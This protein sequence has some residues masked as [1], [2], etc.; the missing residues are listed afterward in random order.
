[1]AKLI[2]VTTDGLNDLL[3]NIDTLK[4]TVLTAQ[5]AGMAQVSIDVANYA[6][7][8]HS[9]QNR[10]ENLENSIGPLPVE[11]ENGTVVGTVIATGKAGMNYAAYVE[12]GT[13]R[14]A[15]YPFMTPAVEANKQ[16]LRDVIAAATEK[17]QQALKV[18]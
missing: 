6:K 1:M 7:Q 18:K 14:S 10:T 8:N 12:Y 2:E 5:A 9:F 15:P 3:R 4:D 17:A 13:A 16:H 11:I